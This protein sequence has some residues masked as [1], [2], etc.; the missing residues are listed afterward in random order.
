[1]LSRIL[2]G[3]S[4]DGSFVVCENSANFFSSTIPTL[5]DTFM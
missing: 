2:S 1:M 5:G 4:S 3:K